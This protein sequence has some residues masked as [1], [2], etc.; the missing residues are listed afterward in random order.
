VKHFCPNDLVDGKLLM[1]KGDRYPT[2]K[3]LRGKII[4]KGTGKYQEIHRIANQGIIEGSDSEN[5]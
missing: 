2:L 3:E 1:V 4:V 5:E